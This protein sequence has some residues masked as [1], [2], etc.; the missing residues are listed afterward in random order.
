MLKKRK[1]NNSIRKKG[2][3]KLRHYKRKKIKHF[4]YRFR[5]VQ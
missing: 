4:R 2:V 1:K 3:K 5:N